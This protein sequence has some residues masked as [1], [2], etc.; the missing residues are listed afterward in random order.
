MLGISTSSFYCR[1]S[2]EDAIYKIHE[3]GVQCAEV[4]L[5]T[6]SEYKK[7]YIQM[8]S[9]RLSECNLLFNSVHTLPT[10][11][12]PQLFALSKRQQDDAIAFFKDILNSASS[13]GC[14]IYVMHGKPFFKKNIAEKP[15]N[16]DSIAS[17]LTELCNIANEYGMQIALEN[18]H[19]AMCNNLEFINGIKAVVPDLRFTLDIKQAHLSGTHYKEYIK[20]FGER[21]VNVHICDYV[22]THTC[23]PGQ[24]KA[25]FNLLNNCLLDAG[26]TGNVILEVYEKDYSDYEQLQSSVNYLT[27]IFRG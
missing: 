15:L 21:L 8:I 5:N 13:A 9:D 20:A 17:V 12:E 10:Q 14:K 18:V 3:L 16:M 26:Y 22:D 25:D 7:D 4:F 11:F 27:E 2:T 24:G 23:L 1:L 19:W 6:Y